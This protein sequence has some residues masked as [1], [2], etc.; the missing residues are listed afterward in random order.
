MADHYQS[1]ID[2]AIELIAESGRTLVLWEEVTNDG[3]PWDDLPVDQFY[4]V[5]GVQTAFDANEIDGD[6][7]RM[8]DIRFLIASGT[9]INNTMRVIDSAAPTITQGYSIKNLGTVRPGA[10]LVLYKIQARV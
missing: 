9:A 4:P 10:S 1:E 7:V 3:G 6:L 5:I 8:D 2:L